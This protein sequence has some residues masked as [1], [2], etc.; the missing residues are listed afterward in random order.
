MCEEKNRKNPAGMAEL[1]ELPYC[2]SGTVLESK[3]SHC[4]RK[5]NTVLFQNEA[6]PAAKTL[7]NYPRVHFNNE[8]S[9]R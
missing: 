5:H 1:F 4:D 9:N 2:T 6:I 7:K 3:L 8:N